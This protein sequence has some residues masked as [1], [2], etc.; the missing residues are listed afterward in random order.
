MLIQEGA[1]FGYS[2]LF[3]YTLSRIQL[4]HFLWETSHLSCLYPVPFSHFDFVCSQF[5]IFLF[6]VLC[7]MGKSPTHTV[8]LRTLFSL[9]N[10]SNYRIVSW[11]GVGLFSSLFCRIH[12]DVWSLLWAEMGYR[13]HQIGLLSFSLCKVVHLHPWPFHAF[14]RF[15]SCQWL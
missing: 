2:G 12:T 8:I 13:L 5:S 9:L 10:F 14:I 4:F 6:F 11:L 7:V 15:P 1:E 3:I